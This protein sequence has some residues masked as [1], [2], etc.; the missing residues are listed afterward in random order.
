MIYFGREYC[1]AKVHTPAECPICSW[2]NSSGKF[3]KTPPAD[4]VSF[5]PQKRAKGL[6]Y[7]SDRIDE[8][9]S[10]PSLAVYSSPSPSPTKRRSLLTDQDRQVK[11]EAGAVVLDFAEAKDEDE[12]EAKSAKIETI[13]TETVDTKPLPTRK[14]KT[15]STIKITET[16][17]LVTEA[18]T[19]TVKKKGGMKIAIEN[20]ENI[21]VVETTNKRA[22]R[23]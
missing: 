9:Q 6:V 3:A 20:S 17:I 22:R 23:K 2:V 8:L 19:A 14:R 21:E 11:L 13:T 7:Y 1:A 16:K 5:S 15:S 18:S 10:N 4:F 12:D